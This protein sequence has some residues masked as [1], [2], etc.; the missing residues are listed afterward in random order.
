[1][2]KWVLA[3]A[4]GVTLCSASG[5]MTRSRGPSSARNRRRLD[6]PHEE[7]AFQRLHVGAGGDH[8]HRDGDPGVVAVAELGEQVFGLLAGGLGDLLA[9]VVALAEL[10]ADDPHDVFGVEVGL[11]EDERL[12]DFGAAGEDF[13]EELSAEGADDQPDL[14]SATTSRSSWLAV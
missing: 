6:V 5:S 1:M 3:L 2:T 9:E 7:Q 14:V 8:V 4:S 12:R 13:G 11:G 10:F